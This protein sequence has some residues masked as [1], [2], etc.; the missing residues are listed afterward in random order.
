MLT[1]SETPD[2]LPAAML[3]ADLLRNCS[4]GHVTSH[5]GAQNQV[6][7]RRWLPVSFRSVL[8]GSIL[9]RT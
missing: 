5:G 1:A 6:S 8:E 9:L 2:T 3:L 7:I 4:V